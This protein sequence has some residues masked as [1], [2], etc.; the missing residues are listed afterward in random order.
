MVTIQGQHVGQAT[1]RAGRRSPGSH[2]ARHL[3][4]TIAAVMCGFGVMTGARAAGPSLVDAAQNKDSAAAI[5]LIDKGTDV[6]ATAA[7]GTTALMWATYNGD[8]AL[9]DRLLKAHAK[10]DARNAYG[11][12][13]LSQA[14]QFGDARI[15]E[16]LLKAGANVEGAN[17]DDQTA[18]MLAARAGNVEV[19]K[20]L[21][22]HGAKVDAREKFRE[23]TA[24]IWAAAEKQPEMVRLLLSWHADPNAR[25]ELNLDRRQV[26][27][28]PRVQARPPGGMTPLLY[29]AR[30][31]CLKC[32]QYL[33]EDGH[34][35]IN[36]ADPDGITPLLI[37]TENFHF[38]L[39]A[40]LIK[41]G[42]DVNRW[43]WWGRTPLY[44]AVD[45]NTLPY[46]GRPDHIS[47]DETS[48]LKLMQLL[49][50]AG[51]NPDAQLKLFPP[52]RSLGADRGGDMLLTIGTTPLAR[53]ARGADSAAIELLLAHHADPDLGNSTDVTPLMLAAGF[54]TSPT[55]TRGRYRT[56]QQALEA[57]DALLKGGADVNASMAQGATALHGAAS[58]GYDSVVKA[59]AAHGAHLDAKD[60]RGLTPADYAMGK[61]AFGRG[62]PTVHAG[63][64]DLIHQ[65]LADTHHPAGPPPTAAITPAI[66]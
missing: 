52:Y 56:E 34:A 55:D 26:T 46:G 37:A 63:T 48:G 45:L 30:E 57:V 16:D 20:Q 5:A 58:V 28:E 60:A 40:W 19:A 41:K 10:V 3:C 65:M 29:A 18:L 32:V 23:Q 14:A 39:A 62:S 15:V 11:A 7:D 12:N 24:L 38:D 54:G 17:P 61:A 8:R 31:G 50:D 49:L 51:A 21:L 33:V 13:A 2:P 9:V 4:A 59:L 22:K 6:D 42:A 64:A 27:A 35:D 47:L 66:R 36:L 44:A 43:D 53:A 1:A 25:S